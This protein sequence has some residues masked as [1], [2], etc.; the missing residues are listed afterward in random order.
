MENNVINPSLLEHL[1]SSDKSVLL[2]T[3]ATLI[4]ST[5]GTEQEFK[6]LQ[7]DF[8]SLKALYEWV[9]ELIPQA[10]C[11]METNGN[12]FYRNAE[13]SKSQI[14]LRMWHIWARAKVK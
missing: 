13:A 6:K 1:N 12:V 2:E 10:I 5:Y 4:Q 3:L 8:N 7:S 9:L 14:C 11:V